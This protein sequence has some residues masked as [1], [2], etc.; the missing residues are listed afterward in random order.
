MTSQAR[1]EANRQNA[2]KSTGPRSAEGKQRVRLNALKHGLRAEEIVLPTES[3][4][5]FNSY[6]AAWID[7]WK[8]TTEARRFLV[9]RLVSA[10]RAPEPA[11]MPTSVQAPQSRLSARRSVRERWC[12]Q[13][14]RNAFAAAYGL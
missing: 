2:Q 4:D 5:D 14:S 11:T 8:P 1:I 7:D 12:A 10:A 3:R 13:A 6:L 9:E